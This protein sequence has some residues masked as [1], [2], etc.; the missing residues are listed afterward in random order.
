MKLVFSA[1]TGTAVEI[2]ARKW[3]A[4]HPATTPPRLPRPEIFGPPHP[5]YLEAEQLWREAEQEAQQT[6]GWPPP[7]TPDDGAPAPDGWGRGEFHEVGPNDPGPAG[8]FWRAM[9]GVVCC[10]KDHAVSTDAHYCPR[11]GLPVPPGITAQAEDQQRRIWERA[12]LN[13]LFIERHRNDY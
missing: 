12:E 1:T 5:L 9:A 8:K 3:Q 11:C 4:K 13:N 7:T 2:Y 6:F 10:P